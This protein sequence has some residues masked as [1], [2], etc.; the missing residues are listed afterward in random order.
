MP[1][2]TP[3]AMVASISNFFIASAVEEFLAAFS[4]SRYPK[5]LLR[6]IPQVWCNGQV[7]ARGHPFTRIANRALLGTRNSVLATHLLFFPLTMHPILLSLLL[8]LTAAAADVF[9]GAV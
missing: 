1:T 4:N 7:L 3:T 5:P 8:G 2:N 9:G 6:S